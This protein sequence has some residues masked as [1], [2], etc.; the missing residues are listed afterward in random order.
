MYVKEEMYE[1]EEHFSNIL[2]HPKYTSKCAKQQEFK[3]LAQKL[4]FQYDS[5]FSVYL[6][7]RQRAI[8]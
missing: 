4:Y 6:Q 8:L 5:S 1:I 2:S 3:H 7:M